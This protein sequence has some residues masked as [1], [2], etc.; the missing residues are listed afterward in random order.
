[1]TKEELMEEELRWEEEQDK[2][3]EEE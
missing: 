1:M 3:Y 2:E